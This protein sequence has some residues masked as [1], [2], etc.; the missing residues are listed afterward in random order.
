M[1]DSGNN[2]PATAASEKPRST[3]EADITKY[4]VRGFR[5]R[6]IRSPFSHLRV[7]VM[8]G[9]SRDRQRRGEE[10]RRITRGGRERPRSLR[11]RR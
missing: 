6:P 9:C 8:E 1:S 3:A 2:A 5:P 10:A 7:A 11:R 4:K